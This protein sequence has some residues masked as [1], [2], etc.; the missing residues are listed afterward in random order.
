MYGIKSDGEHS[1]FLDFTRYCT[2]PLI[3]NMDFGVVER[4]ATHAHQM[5]RE[6]AND[7][8]TGK[9][10]MIQLRGMHNIRATANPMEAQRRLEEIR[11][12][13]RASLEAKQEEFRQRALSERN[14]A[15]LR[16]GV[17]TG[18]GATASAAGGGGAAFVI[19]VFYEGQYAPYREAGRPF[20]DACNQRP[21]PPY[22]M[23]VYLPAVQSAAAVQSQSPEGGG[24]V[25]NDPSAGFIAGGLVTTAGQVTVTQQLLDR[26]GPNVQY[27]Q[28]MFDQ[29]R[30][31]Y[32]R[33]WDKYVLVQALRN[34]G[35]ISLG[36]RWICSCRPRGG[37][38]WSRPA[39][40]SLPR[41][42]CIR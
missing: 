29:L 1:F 24:I 18:G 8:K 26:A 6:V 38:T 35:A 34:G 41:A 30:R 39:R 33:K 5:E 36:R 21:L 17:T 42:A 23:T 13:G 28:I 32:A 10:A 22:G 25:E 15:E 14:G 37:T 3:G 7:T 20:A 2:G 4:M 16:S 27:D 31:D 12:R 9:D 40:W 11:E 19:P